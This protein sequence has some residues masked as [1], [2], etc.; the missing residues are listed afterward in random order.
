MDGRDTSFLGSITP[1][2]GYYDRYPERKAQGPYIPPPA[3]LDT[4]SLIRRSVSSN[5]PKRQSRTSESRM[6]PNTGQSAKAKPV[7]RVPSTYAASSLA[8]GMSRSP[9]KSLVTEPIP[10]IDDIIRNHSANLL[11]VDS[12]PRGPLRSASWSAFEPVPSPPTP[13]AATRRHH[14]SHGRN[15]SR[16]MSSN[17]SQESI[18]SVELEVRSSIQNASE[19]VDTGFSNNTVLLQPPPQVAKSGRKSNTPPKPLQ[20]RPGRASLDQTRDTPERVHRLERSAQYSDGISDARGTNKL[21]HLVQVQA[22]FVRS[23]CVSYADVGD[24]LGHAVMVF[25]G[26][27][28]VR[29]LIGL[30]DEIATTFGLRLVCID[31]WGIGR[32]EA[33]PIDSRSILGW[34]KVVAEIADRLG[35]P[36]FSIMAH[37]AGAPFAVA[38][39]LC[40][41]DRVSGP[42]QLLAP[43]TGFQHDSSYKWLRFVPDGVIKTAQAADWRIQSWK[44]GKADT[45]DTTSKPIS[46]GSSEPTAQ[47]RV[48]QVSDPVAESRPVSE[49]KKSKGTRLGG[50]FGTKQPSS[51]SNYSRDENG[52]VGSGDSGDTDSTD[53]PV[54]AT[55][56]RIVTAHSVVST[57]SPSHSTFSNLSSNRLSPATE[58]P[59]NGQSDRHYFVDKS[60]PSTPKLDPGS[61]SGWSKT[62]D[63]M[64]SPSGL[65]GDLEALSLDSATPATPTSFVSVKSASSRPDGE[66]ALDLLRASH[67][68]SSKGSI[69]DLNLVLG[70]R[71]WGFDFNQLD[72]PVIIWH[73]TRDDRISISNSKTLQKEMPNCTLNTVQN[74]GHNLMTRSEVIFAVLDSIRDHVS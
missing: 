68:E 62:Q 25:L 60:L 31:R 16:S 26:L 4:E 59:G 28:A 36:R 50:L 64:A 23:F 71:P 27:G 17:S 21:T 40:L 12:L 29:H 51:A 6:G 63:P 67:A 14:S 54:R 24:P 73:G 70:K 55:P 8:L 52:N 10:S 11:S 74:A 58:H 57:P 18:N 34:S 2:Q 47:A 22:G 44:L 7:T 30:Y 69:D 45:K 9:T 15:V 49:A 56:P 33:V 1:T 72:H 66:H 13:Q 19:A 46:T 37:S 32:T 53:G 39:A 61:L 41:P 48:R 65:A 38:T 42:V 35:M 43:W 20:H 3:L 5:I